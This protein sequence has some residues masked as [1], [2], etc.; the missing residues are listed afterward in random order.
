MLL[1]RKGMHMEQ[2]VDCVEELLDSHLIA[3]YPDGRLQLLISTVD[4][5]RDDRPALIQHLLENLSIVERKACLRYSTHTCVRAAAYV[6]DL[7]GTN[8]PCTIADNFCSLMARRLRSSK[9]STLLRGSKP[10]QPAIA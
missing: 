6:C 2:V 7:R 10:W 8:V 5:A 3:D 4:M 1:N 9:L